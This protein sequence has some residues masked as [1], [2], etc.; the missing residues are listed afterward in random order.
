MDITMQ[1]QEGE[2]GEEYPGTEEAMKESAKEGEG[3]SAAGAPPT[4]VVDEAEKDKTT[5]EGA[6]PSPADRAPSPAGRSSQSSPSGT[7]TPRPTAIP[8]RPA[9]MDR[10]AND[11][12]APETHEDAL[13]AVDD[14]DE[15]DKRGL[16][17]E[18]RDKLT[19]LRKEQERARKERVDKLT[20]KL[21]DRISVWTET[22]K[23][24]DV[25]EAFRQKMR[26]E[27]EELKMESFGIDI[28]HA[29][30]QTYLSK[31]STLLRSQ[32]FLGI[33]GFFSRLRDKGTMVKD[34][35][36][37]ISSAMEAQAE[38]EKMAKM[39]EEAGEDWTEERKVE[40][41]RRVTGKILTAAWRGSKFEIQD[42]LRSV[43]DNVLGDKAVP[44]AKRLERAQALVLIGD[45]FIKVRT[46]LT[47]PLV[48]HREE[49]L[50]NIIHR[51]CGLPT[52]RA[53]TSSSS[54]SLP[55]RRSRTRTRRRAR[56]R[57]SGGAPSP[58][59]RPTCASP[60]TK[61]PALLACC[62]WVGLAC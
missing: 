24:R 39:E 15:R 49:N 46:L 42:V 40:A 2:E 43:C 37:T 30:G 54:S 45:I 10:P 8:I 36:N 31:G 26:L 44:L 50:T 19:E 32:K 22:D 59:T 6:A 28:C 13:H 20:E 62:T 7:S 3:A 4:V 1:G 57:T 23:G 58:T 51:R 48:G 52:R 55:R 27:V 29:V 25:T 56:T 11:V 53:T 35:W 18:Q 61:A 34:T 21:L 17:K 16:T 60:R 41:E 9:L 12:S 14:K 38:M 33:G 5:A 47:F